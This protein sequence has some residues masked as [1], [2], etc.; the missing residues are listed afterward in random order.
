VL[1]QYSPDVVAAVSATTFAD[2]VLGNGAGMDGHA[3]CDDVV[4]GE[5][6][7]L[8]AQDFAP[9]SVVTAETVSVGSDGV[10]HGRTTS[11]HEVDTRGSL[12]SSVTAPS[13]ADSGLLTVSLTGTNAEGGPVIGTALASTSVD[14][15]C[16]ATVEQSGRLAPDLGAAV[17]AP[18]KIAA[19]DTA[20]DSSD[21]AAAQSKATLSSTGARVMGAAA[22]ALALVTCGAAVLVTTRQR[23]SQS[24]VP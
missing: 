10:E 13:V 5:I 15:A 18:D 19:A 12:I 24:R 20:Q 21:R 22:T 9:R 7:P 2:V 1:D 14:S 23:A 6:I 4:A 17:P 11:H 8:L 3:S 16:V